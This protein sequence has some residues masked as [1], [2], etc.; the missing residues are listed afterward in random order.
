MIVV[1]FALPA[2]QNPPRSWS[3]AQ[4]RA[5]GPGFAGFP[6]LLENGSPDRP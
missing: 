2:G 1:G 3:W 6:G 4:L 5:L